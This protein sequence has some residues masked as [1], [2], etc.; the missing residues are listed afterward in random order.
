IPFCWEKSISERSRGGPGSARCASRASRYGNSPSR[1]PGP[2]QAPEERVQGV[3]GGPH[4]Q[5]GR[6]QCRANAS[7]SGAEIPQQAVVG[8]AL[9]VRSNPIGVEQKVLPARTGV[10]GSTPGG[11]RDV[12]PPV[13][14]AQLSQV[15]VTRAFT[16]LPDERV[17]CASVP[18]AD[19]QSVDGRRVGQQIQGLIEAKMPML[20]IP[21]CTVDPT[22]GGSA[23][24]VGEPILD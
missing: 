17:G 21:C 8:R 3:R 5:Q 18:V 13:S 19:H 7:R 20:W 2:A 22:S 10:P 1:P 24:G 14:D 16:V 23:P 6:N 12:C 9:Q 11:D 4:S 15:D